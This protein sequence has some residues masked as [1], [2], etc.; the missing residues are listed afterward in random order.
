MGLQ[1]HVGAAQRAPGGARP[2]PP[3]AGVHSEFS[4]LPE[5]TWQRTTDREPQRE[6]QPYS[7]SVKRHPVN[8]TETEQRTRPQLS[9]GRLEPSRPVCVCVCDGRA[10]RVCVMRMPNMTSP[11]IVASGQHTT[12]RARARIHTHTHTNARA[13][14]RTHPHPHTHFFQSAE[15]RRGLT[16]LHEICMFTRKAAA[17]SAFYHTWCIA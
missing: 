13:Y 14:A 16:T 9:G 17:L 15:E 1:Q 10:W 4:G 8:G 12:E 11:C 7:S 6:P 2:P 5:D 3:L